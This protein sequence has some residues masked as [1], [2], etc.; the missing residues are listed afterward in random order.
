MPKRVLT[1]KVISNKMQKTGVISVTSLRPH[2]LYAKPIKKTKKYKFHDEKDE[3]NI[4]D[5]AEI[6]ES[7]PYTKEKNWCLLRI[8]NKSG[9]YMVAKAGEQL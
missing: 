4:G 3:C 6:V 8:V 5:L 1:G 2:H 9:E 7:S